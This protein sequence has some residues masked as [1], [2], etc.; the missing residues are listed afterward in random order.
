MVPQHPS[1]LG[2]VSSLMHPPTLMPAP[3]RDFCVVSV[4]G[5]A[6]N[7]L[8]FTQIVAASGQAS[9]ASVRVTRYGVEAEKDGVDGGCVMDTKLLDLP[10]SSTPETRSHSPCIDDSLNAFCLQR[11]KQ[12]HYLADREHKSLHWSVSKDSP[13]PATMD[14][15]TSHQEGRGEQG[16]GR[17]IC[18]EKSKRDIAGS[19]SKHRG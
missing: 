5:G 17:R 14:R 19:G 13:T 15:Q 4:E 7:S 1:L 2:T 16:S 3:V 11:Q 18:Q 12:Q 10:R 6:A 9:G 8:A